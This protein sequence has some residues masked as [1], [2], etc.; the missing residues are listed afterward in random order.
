MSNC[1]NCGKPYNAGDEI[2]PDCGFVFPFTADVLTS[3]T[4]LQ[5]RYVIQELTHTGGMGYIY[6]AKDKKLYDRLCILK[7]VKESVKSDTDLKKLEE[8]ARRMAKLSHPNVAMIL[9]H[10]VEGEYYFLVVERIS[11][12]TLSEVFGEHHGRLSEEEVVNW[13][14]S[15]CD[16]VSYI[17]QQGII[18][19]DISPDNIMLTV[20]GSIKF[21]DFGTLRELRYITT[22]GTAG[23]GKYGYTPPEQWQGKPVPQSDI[24]A[25][26]ATIYYLLT[27]NLPLSKEYLSGQGPQSED[28]SP[29]FPRIRT[30]NPNVSMELEAVLQKA[31]QLDINARYSSAAELGQAL[32]NLRKV[33]VKEA[34]LLSIDSEHLDF[35]SVM[36]GSSETKSLTLKNIGSGRIIG[37]ITTTQPWIKVSPVTIDL[38]EGEQKVLVTVDTSGLASGFN[39]AGDI[40][41]T[42]NGGAAQVSVSLSTTVGKPVRAPVPLPRVSRRKK[43][44]LFLTIALIIVVPLVVIGGRNVFRGE[45]VPSQQPPSTVPVP[46]QQPPPEEPVKAPTIKKQADWPMSGRD[47][48]FTRYTPDLPPDKIKLI[49]QWKLPSEVPPDILVSEDKV[50]AVNSAFDDGCRTNIYCLSTDNG[51]LIWQQSISKPY[52][53]GLQISSMGQGKIFIRSVDTIHCLEAKTG[54]LLWEVAMR[55]NTVPIPVEDKLFFG[56][57]EGV[58]CLDS[59]TGKIIW[60]TTDYFS[61]SGVGEVIVEGD[62][63]YAGHNM[64]RLSCLDI[65]TGRILW[66]YRL[67][68]DSYHYAPLTVAE[69]K[70]FVI[71]EDHQDETKPEL[72][73]CL[74]ADTGVEMWKIAV[75]VGSS[76]L[77]SPPAIGQGKLIIC[78]KDTISCYDPNS[79]RLLWH[80]EKKATLPSG[81]SCPIWAP[82]IAG[83]TVVTGWQGTEGCRTVYWD[84]GSGKLLKELDEWLYNPVLAYGRLFGL[85]F[86]STDEY[87]LCCYGE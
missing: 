23:M 75:D 86:Q 2:C 77:S 80:Q 79:G 33:E 73:M 67:Q 49:W 9:D 48:A 34:A 3:G 21:V 20:E 38:A 26:G 45:Q 74:N 18:H 7:Q 46:S 1:P 78:G 40:N 35:A 52:C 64:F 59:L 83:N 65:S 16:V 19:R 60:K 44:V 37:A 6:L 53:V 76:Y 5:G 58:F 4:I 51:N 68:K 11:G 15:I 29:N 55:A 82:I 50:I 24:F 13:A 30:R 54:K 85:R 70:L 14:V 39:G 27:G 87:S 69:D 57:H 56:A 36:P 84:L 32:K 42:T 63:I 81:G 25:L 17:H 12:K 43:Q 31:L 72:L 10:F 47:S 28:F 71:Y 62:R 66:T 41:V 61:I 8:E 22:R